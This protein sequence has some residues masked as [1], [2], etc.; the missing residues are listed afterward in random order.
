MR[1][2]ML[3]VRFLCELAMLAAFAYW[4]FHTA[5]GVAGVLLGVGAPAVAATVWGLFLAPKR[6][7]ALPVAARVAIELAVFGTAVLALW[8]T[9]QPSLAAG[10]AAAAVLQ[11]VVLSAM[12][13]HS[14]RPR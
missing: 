10:F 3:L 1:A 4:G 11:R 7:I 6:R 2:V 5:N 14:Q 12:G 8:A 9:G 13:E